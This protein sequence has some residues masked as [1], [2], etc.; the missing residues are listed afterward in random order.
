MKYFGSLYL[1]TKHIWTFI[2]LYVSLYDFFLIFSS[3]IILW[4]CILSSWDIL[5]RTMNI[6]SQRNIYSFLP[7]RNM[8][9]RYIIVSQRI[10]LIIVVWKLQLNILYRLMHFALI[11]LCFRLNNI[12]DIVK[13]RKF[14]YHLMYSVCC[15][16]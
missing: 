11:V 6:W 7:V 2:Y 5:C 14:L 1:K 4:N 8:S 15:T 9:Q 3:W 12:C 16:E 13:C 10:V